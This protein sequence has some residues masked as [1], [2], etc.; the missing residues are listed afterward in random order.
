M[1][2]NK[3]LIVSLTEN[4]HCMSKNHSFVQILKIE[5]KISCHTFKKLSLVLGY[6]V[7]YVGRG[8]TQNLT[9]NSYK[10]LQLWLLQWCHALRPAVVLYKRTVL[11]NVVKIKLISGKHL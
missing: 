1:P 7:L 11:C 4:K 10:T 8:R 6:M 3:I 2:H 5:I 9:M